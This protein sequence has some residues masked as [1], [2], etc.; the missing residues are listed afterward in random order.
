MPAPDVSPRSAWRR[1]LLAAA[2]AAAAAALLV[3][4]GAAWFGLGRH[5][6]VPAPAE[7][8]YCGLPAAASAAPHPGMAWVPAGSFDFGDS[9]YPEEQPVVRTRVAGFWMDR[10]EVINDE[11]AKFVQATGYVTVAER[12]VDS[13][14]HPGLQIG[15]AH[16]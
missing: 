14:R 5:A 15:R 12:E 13:Q 16:V 8:L 10:T 7:R 4:G 2:A 9:V 1:G 3:V 6:A 11:F